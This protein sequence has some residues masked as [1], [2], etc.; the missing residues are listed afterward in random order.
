MEEPFGLI[1]ISICTRL[2]KM[3][4][5][6]NSAGFAETSSWLGK[7]KFTVQPRPVTAD[8]C[9]LP[10][11]TSCRAVFFHQPVQLLCMHSSGVPVPPKQCAHAYGIGSVHVSKRMCCFILKIK[12][13]L[14]TITSIYS[15]TCI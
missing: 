14:N 12:E 10:I 8:Q 1:A 6:E 5:W 2:L 11:T 7:F 9:C 13:K 4:S 15:K 3:S